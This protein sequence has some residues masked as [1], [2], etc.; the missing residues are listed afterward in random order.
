MRLKLTLSILLYIIGNGWALA[1]S[2]TVYG[3][4]TSSN[5][6]TPLSGV[7]ILVKGTTTYTVTNNIG[8]YQLAAQEGDILVFQYPAAATQEVAVKSS[9]VNIRLTIDDNLLDEVIVVAYTTA[10][11]ANY[12]GSATVVKQDAIE[13]SQVSSI[14]N[15]LHGNAIGV[16]STL[17][18]G[19]PGS[20]AIL[21]VRGLGSIN[22]SA[23]PLY[24]VDGVPYSGDIN[25]IN[26]ADIESITVL[27]DAAASALYGS[28]SANGII[29]VTSKQGSLNQ[30]PK[31]D[32]RFRYGFSDRAVAGYKQVSTN[33][34]F[35]LYWEALR[36]QQQYINGAS[37][38]TAASYATNNLTS[39]LGINPYGIAYPQPIGADGNLASGANP[40][41][42][43]SWAEACEQNASRTETLV[44]ISGGGNSST[45]FASFGYLNNQGVAIGSGFKRYSG[46]L[47]L[48][49]HLKSWLTFSGN[50]SLAHTYQDSPIAEGSDPYNIVR[51]PM[52][53]PNFYPIWER[54]YTNGNFILDQE[55]NKTPDFG[56]YRPSGATP[57]SNLPA[58][59]PLD[60][61]V[62]KNDVAS[63][64]TSL[65]A[66]ILKGLSFKSSFNLDYSNQNNHFY[67]NPLYGS[68]V[69]TGGSVSKSN[70]R[71]TGITTNNILSYSTRL[72]NKHEV[73]TLLG[74]EYYQYNQGYIKGSRSNFAL[75]NLYEPDA[76]SILSDFSGK[77][78]VYKLLSFFGS[79]EYGY[80]KRYH[81]SASLRTDG[82]SRFHPNS[83]WGTFWSVGASWRVLNESF[84]KQTPWIS[85][86]T[87]RTSYGLQ[88]NDNIGTFYAYKSL[89]AINSYLG[90]QGT[91]S[92]SIETSKLKWESNLNYNA[93][94]DFGFLSNRIGGNIE[95]FHRNS[96]DLLFNMPKSP[97]IGYSSMYANI[98]SMRNVGFE[99][100]L[101][102]S[103]I[104]TVVLKWDLFINLT[105]YKNKIIHLPQ[106]EF[107]LGPMRMVE[108]GS[109]YEY[110][111][112]EWAGVDSKDGLPQW[113]KTDSNGNR[114]LTKSYNEASTIE[115]RINA[116]SSLPNVFGGFGTNLSYKNI[117]F[118]CLF[119][120][121]IGGKI[122]S[123]DKLAILH[124]GSLAGRAWSKEILNRWTPEN[125]ITNVPRLQ[126]TSTS[127]TEP[128][129]RFLVDGTYLRLKNITLSYS[130]PQG[131]MSKM[132]VST[133]KIFVQGENILTIFKEEGLDP[134][135]TPDGITNN[136]YP[137]MKSFSFGVNISF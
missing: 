133:C 134:E 92:Y 47:Q 12:T 113:Y 69:S 70:S 40:L 91:I 79:V 1:Q 56:S 93:G 51:S 16:Q 98:G 3:I 48:N 6:G 76:A 17:Y 115:S 10:N 49:S 5:D 132:F 99:L 23:L 58:S 14:S 66:T 37:E 107:I 60:L 31:V 20:N 135:Q 119:A 116:G 24:I 39:R 2:H 90:E 126:T 81:L 86:L 121:S 101:N 74:H 36:N 67:I 34:Y 123:G 11:K 103:P 127:W 117:D 114:V 9:T 131:W 125:T 55:G 35:T 97:S 111:L 62:R 122:Y 96:Q 100:S 64:R 71:L 57:N 130:L 89:Y 41:W 83:R 78:D 29:I 88:G 19:Q 8:E 75:P 136:R 33:E 65:A 137:V 30:A 22:S 27:K 52:L 73:K 50:L 7:T 84:I 26:P 59:T 63:I 72:N 32:L 105:H 104:K 82:S 38:A 112:P 45:Y 118:S 110:F 21:L 25:A 106:H 108:G 68:G 124:G 129:T 120:Y 85:N 42:N 44:G 18:S 80:D 94:I 4:V 15:V 61:N 46:R 128:S 54:D 95:F 77:S 102:G 13:K 109:M 87:I 53:I 28:R 43:D